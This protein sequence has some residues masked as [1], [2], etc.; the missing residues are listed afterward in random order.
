MILENMET[1]ERINEV[2][3]VNWDNMYKFLKAS[4]HALESING[5]GNTGFTCPLCGSNASISKMRSGGGRTMVW[6]QCYGC[7]M[8]IIS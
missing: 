2:D 3:P 8:K 1:T 6:S 7:E 4:V 5:Y